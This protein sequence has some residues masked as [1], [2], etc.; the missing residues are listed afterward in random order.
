MIAAGTVVTIT[1]LAVGALA[2]LVYALRVQAVKA[3]HGAF[4]RWWIRRDPAAYLAK[5][6]IV[7]SA[8]T[9]IVGLFL[10]GV[11]AATS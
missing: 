11:A 1:G 10:A 2:A 5:S 9:T 7:V 6:A 4:W 3:N 8:V